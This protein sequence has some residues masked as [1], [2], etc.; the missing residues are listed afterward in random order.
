[1]DICFEYM[2]HYK[3]MNESS[4]PYLG[5]QALCEYN[6]AK[7]VV[8]LN[9]YVNVQSYSYSALMTAVAKQ[10]VSIAIEADQSVMQFYKSGIISTGCGDNLDHGVLV[11]G[12]GSSNG[13]P[14]WIVKNSWGTEWGIAGYFYLAMTTT[15][16]AGVCGMYSMPSYPTL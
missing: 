14:Y 4:Y 6:S 8:S 2:T 11:I 7:G 9:G 10:P 13:T 16:G 15:S 12:Y 5:V 3:E 1:M